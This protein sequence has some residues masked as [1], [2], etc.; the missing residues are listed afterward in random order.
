[1]PGCFLDTSALA[2]LY[3]PEIG[4]E[5]MESLNPNLSRKGAK[6]AKKTSF[7]TT[8]EHTLDK[9]CAFFYRAP[10]GSPD[11]LATVIF[12]SGSTGLP[13]GVMLS[14]H[15]ILSNNLK[16]ARKDRRGFPG[17]LVHHRGHRV[18]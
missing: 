9:L 16:S 1:V 8:D 7:E 2:K 3:H 10:R 13:K 15:N 6:T 18:D 14:H 12:S 11:D 4:S 5:R 17:R